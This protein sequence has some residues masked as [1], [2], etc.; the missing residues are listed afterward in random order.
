MKAIGSRGGV[1]N[2]TSADEKAHQAEEL[3][4]CIADASYWIEHYCVT[5]DP[6]LETRY[7]SFVPFPRQVE[8]LDWLSVRLST[9]T[10][11][12][13]EKSKDVGATFVCSYFML[14]Q[15]L[16]SE[17]FAGGIGSR[18]LETVDRLGDPASIFEKFR[19]TLKRLP[20]WMMPKGF[21]W[22]KHSLEGRLINPKMGSTLMGDGGR[23]IGRGG[24]STMYLLDEYNFLD[25][26]EQADAALRDN[27][28]VIIYL[29][30]PNG[31]V[32]TY[33]KREFLPT[34]TFHWSEDPRK[35]RWESTSGVIKTEG[36]GVH[37]L[38]ELP[39]YKKHPTYTRAKSKHTKGGTVVIYPWYEEQCRKNRDHPWII[40]QEVDIS[41][42]GSGFPRYNREFLIRLLDELP[43]CLLD[44][45]PGESSWS[46]EVRTFC[47]PVR[48]HRYLLVSDVAEGES[49]A[50]GKANRESDPDFS[51]THVYD[52]EDWEQVVHYRGRVDTHAYAIDLAV[53]GEMYNWADI[54]VERTGPGI[55]TI[56]A[57]TEEIGYP[58]VWHQGTSETNIKGGITASATSKKTSENELA[59]YIND[60]EEGFPG[61][62]WNERNTIEELV[63]KVVKPNGRCEAE[64]KWHDD[65]CTCCEMA[66]MLL[67][68]VTNR[69]KMLPLTPNKPAVYYGTPNRTMMRWGKG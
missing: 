68:M 32:G 29:G 14:H 21:D 2:A 15:W 57:L 27:S 67:P 47:H 45:L 24:R 46:A 16:W 58:C 26:P 54:A 5:Y 37:P 9:S 3:R 1:V 19:M 60:M 33:Q 64:S 49:N 39:T 34:F 20:A 18:D 28:N 7:M 42:I 65:E 51:V 66:A 4:R 50:E 41:H 8:L 17:G 61:F 62:V 23:N 30:T 59:G 25:H 36:N 52:V 6:R 44:E 31:L 56:K 40:A 12:V 55:A 10:P 11:G 22:R 63:H 35:N 13:I 69:R 53:L 48:G 43:E 38:A